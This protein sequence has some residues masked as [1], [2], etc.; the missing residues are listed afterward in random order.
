VSG[1]AVAAVR[2][3]VDG[4]ELPGSVRVLAVRVAG[5]FGAPT[6]CEI[7]M[8]DPAGL[9]AWPAPA[10]LDARVSVTVVGDDDALFVGEIT[11]VELH[12]AADGTTTA[13]LRA[14]DVLHRL[15]KRQTLRVLEKVDAAA[16]ARALTGDLDVEVDGGSGASMARVV[17]HRQSDFD[18][19]VESAARTGHMVALDGRTLR[20]ATLDGHGDPVPLAFGSTLFEASVEAN[21]GRVAASVAAIGWDTETAQPIRAVASNP[22]TGRRIDYDVPAGHDMSLVEQPASSA[23]DAAAAAQYALDVRTASGVVLRGVAA[24]DVRLRPGARVDVTGIGDAI[25]GRHV[26]C[27]VVH[28]VDADSFQ[29]TFS[30]EPPVPPVPER[31][32]AV[33]L[34]LVTAVD[35]PAGCGRVRVSLPAFGDIDAGWLGVVC[36]GAGRGKGLVALPDVGDTVAVALPHAEPTAGLVLGSLY[37]AITPPDDGVA[38]NAVKRWSLHTADGQSI[39]IDDAAHSLRLENRDGSFLEIAPDTVRVKATTDLVLDASG[40]GIT[41]KASTVDFEHALT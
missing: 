29:T 16:V 26:I 1:L 18:L 8:H 11:C 31:G 27:Q 32:A 37:G 15:R 25:D 30:T 2:I 7:T 14:Y 22:R 41:V 17:Q 34:G 35:D 20:L 12:R 9:K 39:V 4:A 19:L 23:D 10:R 36:P 5:R 28:T 13:R 38:G 3:T 24:G 33:T 40:H 6:Q 21:T